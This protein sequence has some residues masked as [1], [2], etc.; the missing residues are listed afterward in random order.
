MRMEIIFDT[1]KAEWDDIGEG[2]DGDYDPNDPDDVQL[3]R[4]YTYE[5]NGCYTAESSR[6]EWIEIDGGSFCTRMPTTTAEKI[7]MKALMAVVFELHSTS[8]SLSA[9]ERMSWITPEEFS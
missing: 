1:Y 2:C 7:L 8:G 6:P 4:F 9:L 3:L 5:F